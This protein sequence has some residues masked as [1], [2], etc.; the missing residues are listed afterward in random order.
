MSDYE[1]DDFTEADREYNV[2]HMTEEFGIWNNIATYRNYN[3]AIEHAK[4]YANANPEIEV[5]IT[6]LLAYNY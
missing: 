3:E 4:D 1:P 6:E 5:R 2:E